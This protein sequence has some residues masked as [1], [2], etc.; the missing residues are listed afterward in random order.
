MNIHHAV[1]DGFHLSKF[2]LEVQ[3]LI[4]FLGERDVSVSLQ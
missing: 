1:A 4:N 2:F 3:E